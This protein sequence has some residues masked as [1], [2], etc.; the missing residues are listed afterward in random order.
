MRGSIN[1]TRNACGALL[2]LAVLSACAS[3]AAPPAEESEPAEHLLAIG[4]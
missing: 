2:T 1:Q 3:G 4:D